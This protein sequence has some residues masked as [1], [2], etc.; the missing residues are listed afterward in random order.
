MQNP[1][2]CNERPGGEKE[3]ETSIVDPMLNVVFKAKH[4][5]TLIRSLFWPPY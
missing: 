2:I 5:T 3:R 4:T 1:L